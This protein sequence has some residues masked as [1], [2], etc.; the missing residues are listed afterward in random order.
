MKHRIYALLS[1]ALSLFLFPSFFGLQA[2]SGATEEPSASSSSSSMERSGETAIGDLDVVLDQMEERLNLS[3]QYGVSTAEGSLYAKAREKIDQA[4]ELI[5]KG[6]VVSAAPLISEG[7]GMVNGVYNEALIRESN[8]RLKEAKGAIESAE[9]FYKSRKGKIGS[10]DAKSREIVPVIDDYLGAGKEALESAGRNLEQKRYED[11]LADS[12]EAIN[13]GKIIKEQVRGLSGEAAEA[14]T[15]DNVG[16]TAEGEANTEENTHAQLA[17]SPSEESQRETRETQ[18]ERNAAPAERETRTGGHYF[19]KKRK[20]AESLW[21][22]AG[23]PDVLGDPFKWRL[24]YEANRD[25]I[26][27]P[28]LIYPGQ[29][30][31]I[32]EKE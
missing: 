2:Q 23:R 30:L 11:S 15:D 3:R 7:M 18:T 20:P 29:N 27:N 26:K 10:G 9:S 17:E 4:R 13:L 25:K 32:P 5:K 31:V 12:H 6:D 24:I 19:V 14:Q 28:D 1:M 16:E 22:I 8:R 21:R